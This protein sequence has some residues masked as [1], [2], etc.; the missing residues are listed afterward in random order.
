M[1]PQPTWQ[2]Y[3]MTKLEKFVWA[4]RNIDFQQL[5][6]QTNRTLRSIESAYKRASGKAA[7]QG[8]I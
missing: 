6:T 1:N 8:I 4:N 5:A 7:A 3:K 2:F